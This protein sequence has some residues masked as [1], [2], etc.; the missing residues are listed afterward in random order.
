MTPRFNDSRPARTS[1]RR[2]LILVWFDFT[3]CSINPGYMTGFEKCV[4]VVI[5]SWYF[6]WIMDMP[7]KIWFIWLINMEGFPNSDLLNPTISVVAA[8]TARKF[9]GRCIALWW[10]QS[11]LRSDKARPPHATHRYDIF[12]FKETPQM[13]C[14]WHDVWL[15]SG[16]LH[17]Q[18]EQHMR[19]FNIHDTVHRCYS[20]IYD[21]VGLLCTL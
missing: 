1:S 14:I 4:A 2:C 18:A 20:H 15:T 21:S 3:Q 13:L 12:A 10:S 17:R 11:A 8:T 16:N 9:C 7:S 5:I 19:Y 6:F